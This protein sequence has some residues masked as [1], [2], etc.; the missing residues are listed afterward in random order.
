MKFKKAFTLI[1]VL[2][3]FAILSFT[4]AFAVP[5]AIREFTQNYLD[6][7]VTTLKSDIYVQQQKSYT[8]IDNSSHGIAFF[9][10]RYI[11]FTGDSYALASDTEV[12]ILDNGISI[13]NIDFES[14]NELI[15]SLGLKTP[16]SEGSF[17]IS[18]E[19]DSI[20]VSINSAGIIEAI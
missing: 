20:S 16:V 12:F 10:D 2:L 3:V 8:G 15:F 19:A 17:V 4:V 13:N 5:I 18:N 14:G 1:E 7:T 9:N 11:L 6:S